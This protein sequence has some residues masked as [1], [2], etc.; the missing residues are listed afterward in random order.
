MPTATCHCGAVQIHVPFPPDSLTECNC[1]MCRRYGALWA[2]YQDTDVRL[3]A[4]PGTTDEYVWGE[5]TY[6]YLRCKVCGCV[7]QWREIEPGSGAF[8]GVNARNFEPSIIERVK[9][10][11]LDGANSWE[12][13]DRP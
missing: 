10:R 3:I 11:L 2:Y 7:M 13:I 9:V 4:E 12:Y 1:S 8:A 5:R 6:K